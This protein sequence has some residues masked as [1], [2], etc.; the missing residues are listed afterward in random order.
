M[1]CNGIEIER[2]GE[3][4][5]DVPVA[6]VEIDID[7]EWD[8]DNRVYMWGARLRRG[9]DDTSAQYFDKFVEWDALD[10]PRERALAA[11][12]AAWLRGQHD[13]ANARGQTLKVFHWS[14]PERSKLKSILGLAE[15]GDLIDPE[16]GVFVDLGPC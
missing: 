12:F 14:H 2:T 10:S 15:I 16:A 7:I 1:I 3:G 9:T 13:A 11:R 6:D 5:V 8:L 4:P